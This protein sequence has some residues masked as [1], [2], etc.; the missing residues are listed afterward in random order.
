MAESK[1]VIRERM[2][3]G[4]SDYYDKLPGTFTWELYQASATEFE[5]IQMALDSGLD[6]AFAG[7]ADLEHLKVMAFEDRGIVYKDA[8]F[9][10][11]PVK[12]TGV[13]GAVLNIGDLVSNE[14]VEYKILESK[15][16][17]ST[18]I[19]NVNVEC[20]T[21]GSIGNTP[22]G[23]IT[24]F[25][26]SLQGINSVTNEVAFTNGYDEEGRES[27][28]KRYYLEIQKPATSGN[29]HHY[30]LWALSVE[31]VGA[32]KVKPTWNGGG[33]VKVVILNDNKEISTQELID[34]TKAYIETQRPVNADVTVSTATEKSIN[35]NCKIQ[36][37]KDYVLDSVKAEIE[38]NL[39]AHFK[40]KAFVDQYIYYAEIGNI[41]FNTTGVNNIDYTTFTINGA[42]DD[43]ILL[44]TNQ[45]TEIAKVGTLTI[46]TS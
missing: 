32:V 22:V 11:N 34:K 23:T 8:T 10:S 33:T 2:L 40:E 26:K 44:D 4:L 17:D 31:G 6:Q 1:D 14:L 46:T 3:S 13:Q 9:A 25:P 18:G 39:V 12:I 38:K 16:I 15:T 35:I 42:K 7:T 45:E 36:L 29:I 27:L 30:E 28:L 41:I 37:T 20:T 21:A 5:D 19:V 43:I 24:K